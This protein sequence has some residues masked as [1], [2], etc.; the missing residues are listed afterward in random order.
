VTWRNA[1]SIGSCAKKWT[2]ILAFLLWAAIASLSPRPAV[3]YCNVP[4]PRLV[5]A[6]YFASQ[7][8][9]ESTLIKIRVIHEG[10]DPESIG[11]HVY[12]MSVD[13]TLRGKIAG[14]VRVYEG[15]DSGRATFDWAP[16]GKYLLFLFY[17]PDEKSWALDG[18][19]N[20]GPLTGAKAALSAIEEIQAARGGGVIHGAV[21]RDALS[22]P[23]SGLHVEARGTK[24]NYSAITNENGEFQMKVPSGRYSIRVVGGGRSFQK[25]DI[26]YEDPMRVRI[27]PGGCAQVQLAEAEKPQ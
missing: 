27:E 1:K 7:L 16:G 9:V 26:S 22:T 14:L 4:Q 25:A 10:N 18:C 20:S 23:I 6:E 11:A 24:G 17:V 12:S 5:C 15:N 8:V 2:R 21:S 13:K 19:G 3:A